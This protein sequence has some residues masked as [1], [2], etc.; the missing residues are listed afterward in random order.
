MLL[1]LHGAL[2][3]AAQLHPLDG[4]LPGDLP[5]LIPD[6]AGHGAA[7]LDGG[8]FSIGRFADQAAAAIAGGSTAPAWIFGYSMGG[9]V[10]LHLAASRPELVAGVV[11]LGTRVAWSSDV[12]ERECAQ[13]DPAMI[14][15]KVPRFA[16]VLAERH[17]ALGW[18][19]LLGH[20][21][22]LLREL[23]QRPLVTFASLGT[24]TCPVRLML[25]DRDTSVSLEETRDAVR[26]LPLGEMEV[27]P[28][29]PHPLERVAPDRL[30]WTLRQFMGL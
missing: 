12:A 29:T 6:L 22:E 21:A 11:T 27:L 4:R 8:A 14:Q 28:A 3:A 9:Y 18:R 24:I 13:L 2:G 15:A 30:A 7:P 19:R 20:T 16:Q 1:M 10:A 25:G 26:Q 23:G 5:I 17:T